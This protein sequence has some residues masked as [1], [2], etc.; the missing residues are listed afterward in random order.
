MN[1]PTMTI[2]QLLA[3]MEEQLGTEPKPMKLLSGL[4]P[5]VV[6]EHARFK[7]FLDGKTAIPDKYKQ[8]MNVAVAVALG[9]QFCTLTYARLALRKGCSP[10]EVVEAMLVARFVNASTIFAT[11][12]P[13]MEMMLDENKK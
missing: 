12:I 7:M 3:K 6:F 1:Q 9:S 10:E 5:D 8:L 4:M 11:S 13:A 2:E